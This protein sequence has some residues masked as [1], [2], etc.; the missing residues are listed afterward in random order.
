MIHQCYQQDIPVDL[1]GVGMR[2]TG[3]LT[4]QKEDKKQQEEFILEQSLSQLRRTQDKTYEV[5]ACNLK[6][7]PMSKALLV[8]VNASKGI[9]TQTKVAKTNS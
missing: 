1:R 2:S 8:E 9:E 4:S 7:E 5:K 6:G 3:S